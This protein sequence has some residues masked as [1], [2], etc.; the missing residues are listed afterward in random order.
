MHRLCLILLWLLVLVLLGLFRRLGRSLR[1]ISLLNS[2]RLRYNGLATIRF[3]YMDGKW[4]HALGLRCTFTVL[5][6][7]AT[8]EQVIHHRSH[9]RHRRYLTTIY[10]EAHHVL[11]LWLGAFLHLNI[12]VMRLLAGRRWLNV[13]IHDRLGPISFWNL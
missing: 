6:I 3:L 9:R 13:E 4:D 11:R 7:G 10:L 2:L 5:E 12:D 8:R 1:W